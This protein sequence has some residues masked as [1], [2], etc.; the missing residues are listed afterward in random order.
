M[1]DAA[2]G[3][4]AAL[5]DIGWRLFMVSQINGRFVVTM[6]EPENHLHP[7]MQRTL[8]TRLT[9][10]FP[11]AQFIVATHSPFIVS[12][13]RDARVYVLRYPPGVAEIA[14]PASLR[15]VYSERLDT[16]NRAASANEILREVLGVEVT[17]PEWVIADIHR[18]VDSYAQS[19][20]TVSAL[21]RLREQLAQLGYADHYSTALAELVR[22]HDQA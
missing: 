14:N 8:L 7:S 17:A 6:D 16:V 5:I 9:E 4:I 1:L 11:E 21:K 22:R 18:V 3:G 10:A 19:N 2:S 13:V 12:S 15:K 20:L